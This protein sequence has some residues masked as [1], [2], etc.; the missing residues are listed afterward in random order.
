MGRKRNK[1]KSN[2]IIGILC[3]GE[4]EKQYFTM[5]KQKYRLA[6]IKIKVVAADLSGRSLVEKA[7]KFSKYNHLDKTYVA[8]DRDEHSKAELRECDTLAQKNGIAIMFSSI[9]FEIWILMHFEPVTRSYTRD[10]LVQKL[11]KTAYFNQDYSRFK[12]NSYR[13][14]IFDKVQNAVDHA[15]KLYQKNYDWIN[16]DPFT[17]IQLYLPEIFKRDNF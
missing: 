12:G 4:S 6:N 5:L 14:Y 8:F 13:E 7:I 11:S 1:V 3:E 17:N 15:D 16:D 2:P 10:E 9:D